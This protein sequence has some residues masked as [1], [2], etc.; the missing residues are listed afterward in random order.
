MVG[1]RETLRYRRRPGAADVL[2]DL[3]SDIAGID[4]RKDEDVGT[5]CN[6]TGNTFRRRGSGNNRGIELKLAVDV[7]FASACP[8]DLHRM[9]DSIDVRNGN[10]ASPRGRRQERNARP[11]VRHQRPRPNRI[12]YDI[13]KLVNRRIDYGSGI[14][15][16]QQPARQRTGDRL[17]ESGDGHRLSAGQKAN[18][19][20]PGAKNVG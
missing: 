6:R 17:D 13:D 3:V 7:E 19:R 2:G 8:D 10:R 11:L 14:C 5:A 4:A 1:A 9:P 18:E 20:Q 15:H 16:E 12:P